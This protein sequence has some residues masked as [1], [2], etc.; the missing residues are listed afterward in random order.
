M[1]QHTATVVTIESR[2]YLARTIHHGGKFDV[3]ADIPLISSHWGQSDTSG[4]REL[5]CSV[6]GTLVLIGRRPGGRLRIPSMLR[7][8]QIYGYS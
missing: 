2:T 8:T 4:M 6:L 3:R 7:A 1:A 5:T